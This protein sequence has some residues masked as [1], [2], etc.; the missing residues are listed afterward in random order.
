[1]ICKRCE[2]RALTLRFLFCEG[3]WADI[4]GL[5]IIHEKYEGPMPGTGSTFAETGSSHHHR[6]GA[7]RGRLTQEGRGRALKAC[8]LRCQSAGCAGVHGAL[9]KPGKKTLMGP[10]FCAQ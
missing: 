10:F 8:T 6:P 9:G 1:M 7:L 4:T 3:G 2:P 5:A